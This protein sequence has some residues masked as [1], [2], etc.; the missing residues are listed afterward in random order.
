MNGSNN[1]VYG[2]P[3]RPSNK[4]LTAILIFELIERIIENDSL[5][6]GN[7]NKKFHCRIASIA[8]LESDILQLWLMPIILEC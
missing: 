3:F 1:I 2:I 7:K 6:T 8:D 5:R 4:F